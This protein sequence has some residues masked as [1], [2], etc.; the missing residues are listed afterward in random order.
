MPWGKISSLIFLLVI[1]WYWKRKCKTKHRISVK[2]KWFV[3]DC[4]A[5]FQV[6]AWLSK[7]WTC[8]YCM[9]CWNSCCLV[10][11]TVGT[12][13][14]ATAASSVTWWRYVVVWQ[15][16][17]QVQLFC[18]TTLHFF[19]PEAHVPQNWPHWNEWEG[20]VAWTIR[21]SSTFCYA[22][23]LIIIINLFIKTRS[24]L[25]VMQLSEIQKYA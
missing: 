23:M 24:S 6:K 5:I 17:S 19:L 9:A 13:W 18:R 21:N 8:C 2:R 11:P 12:I 20:K 25:Y 4:S 16:L 3:S 1:L 10:L 14:L 7:T 15:K 22:C